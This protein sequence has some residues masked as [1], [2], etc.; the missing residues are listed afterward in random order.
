MILCLLFV[1]GNESIVDPSFELDP[2]RH[3]IHGILQQAVKPPKWIATHEL[4]R[5]DV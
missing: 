4:T 5:L 1:T 2:L 3:E